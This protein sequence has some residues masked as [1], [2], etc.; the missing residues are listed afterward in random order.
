MP[1]AAPF[2]S[3]ARLWCRAAASHTVRVLA[4]CAGFA[5]LLASGLHSGRDFASMLQGVFAQ[6]SG[7]GGTNSRHVRGTL[8]AT[9]DPADEFIAGRVG[10]LLISRR[11][12]DDCLRMLFDNRSGEISDAGHVACGLLAEAAPDPAHDRAELLRRAFRK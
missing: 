7:Q 8:P 4:I 9:L 10:Q 1:I 3:S 12:R 6:N 2:A 5:V 11:N